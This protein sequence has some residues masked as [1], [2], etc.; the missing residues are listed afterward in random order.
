MEWDFILKNSFSQ[1]FSDCRDGNQSFI[2]LK[3]TMCFIIC[4]III[5]YY[6]TMTQEVSNMLLAVSYYCNHS[7]K[8]STQF[9][10]NYYYGRLTTTK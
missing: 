6:M 10:L 5:I 2:H 9:N 8:D 3:D 7:N 1:I 4:I